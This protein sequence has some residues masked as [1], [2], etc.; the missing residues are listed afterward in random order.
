MLGLSARRTSLV[1]DP[2]AIAGIS[3]AL[4]QC[5]YA[6]A[7][8]DL[9]D[10]RLLVYSVTGSKDSLLFAVSSNALVQRGDSVTDLSAALRA[11]LKE[12]VPTTDCL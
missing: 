10:S 7:N 3:A 9:L 12:A 1:T 6:S 2:T 5:T 8:G 4:D 11:A